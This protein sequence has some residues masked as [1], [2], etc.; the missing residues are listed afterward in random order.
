MN[1]NA[2]VYVVVNAGSGRSAAEDK[3]ALLRSVLSESGRDF[4]VLVARIE[5]RRA[6]AAR[7]AALRADMDAMDARAAMRA[8]ELGELKDRMYALEAERRRVSA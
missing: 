3:V 7:V 6:A 8:I 2:P 4:E 1:P 5:R